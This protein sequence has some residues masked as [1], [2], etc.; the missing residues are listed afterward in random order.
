MKRYLN[1]AVLACSLCLAGS[2]LAGV[3]GGDPVLQEPDGIFTLT[4][5]LERSC[6][7]VKIPLTS[8]QSLAGF[9]WYN[10]DGQT[11]FAKLLVASG[12]DAVPPLYIDGVVAAEGVLG[13][14]LGWSTYSFDE[15]YGSLTEALYLIFQFPEEVE[16]SGEAEGPGIGYIAD[17]GTSSIFLSAEGE[18]WVRLKT[19]FSLLVEPILVAREPSVTALSMS[20]PEVELAEELSLP[21]VTDLDTPYPNPFNPMTNI[22]YSLVNASQVD[23]CIFD[24]RGRLVKTLANSYHDPG[25]YVVQWLGKNNQG[26][27]VASGVYFVRLETKDQYFSKRISLL[28]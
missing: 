4:P 20:H 26:I 21:L 9:K 14:S 12:Q 2:A 11:P 8:T 27:T 22:G 19:E 6:I 24:I 17:S 3:G 13:E 15:P 28:K 1:Y 25:R 10:N 18:E 16:G 5:V 7:A 23:L